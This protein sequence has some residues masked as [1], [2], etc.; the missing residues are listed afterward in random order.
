MVL[1]LVLLWLSLGTAG[2]TRP[3]DRASVETK[4]SQETSFVP[5]SASAVERLTEVAQYYQV[6]MGIEWVGESD[7]RVL[8]PLYPSRRTVRSL[9][10]AILKQLPGYRARVENGVVNIAR[11]DT[12]DAPKN[13]LNL[14]IPE[15]RVDQANLHDANALLRLKINMTLHP[16][17]YTGGVGG[18]Y[19]YGV[20]SE[21]R[22]DS[23]IIT[24][25]G[26]SLTVREILNKIVAINA[27]ALW[28]VQLVPSK[29]MTGEPF[30]AQG[31]P[32]GAGRYPLDFHWQFLPLNK[33][34]T[35]R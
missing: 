22:F 28:V 26:R 4:L 20:P 11:A 29:T 32:D 10:A 31:P 1:R 23:D 12:K 16:D 30:F 33:V 18:G 2:Q 34:T 25:S 7:I 19:G 14:R 5:Q 3:V 9:I 27:N 15:F 17:R 21:D 6:P 13:F 35:T 8:K 24:F